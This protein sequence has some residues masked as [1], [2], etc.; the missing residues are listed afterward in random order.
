MKRLW[1][2]AGRVVLLS[3]GF[4]IVSS[5]P[6][7]AQ[8]PSA[9]VF[10]ANCA[11]CHGNDGGANTVMGKDL[12]MRDLRSPEVQKRTDANLTGLITKGMATM[13]GF[14]DKLTTVEIQQQVAYIRQIAK[15]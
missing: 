15:K 6:A 3:A 1:A 13:P 14:K 11:K 9:S 12:K 5:I 10:K 8:S 2:T 7:Q 4:L